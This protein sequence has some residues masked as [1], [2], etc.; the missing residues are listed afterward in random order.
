[1]KISALIGQFLITFNIYENLKEIKLILE[2][3]QKDDLVFY[4]KEHYQVTVMILLF[5]KMSM[6]KILKTQ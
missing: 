6:W 1:M 5:S 4:L 2:K 3:S